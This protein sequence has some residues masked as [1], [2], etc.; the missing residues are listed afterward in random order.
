MA[1]IGSRCGAA[2]L[3]ALLLLC[4]CWLDGARGVPYYVGTIAGNGTWGSVDGVGTSATFTLMYAMVFEPVTGL[5]VV[6]DTYSAKIRSVNVTD[7]TVIT[8]AGWLPAG[9]FNYSKFCWDGTG[10]NA[11]VYFPTGIVADGR[12]NVV[13]CD[14]QTKFIRNTSVSAS[15]YSGTVT[16]WTTPSACATSGFSG[17]SYM[18]AGFTGQMATANFNQPQFLVTDASGAL[19]FFEQGGAA[20]TVTP[21]IRKVVNGAISTVV[22]DYTRNGNRFLAQ[23]MAVD[24]GGNV[25]ITGT[26]NNINVHYIVKFT[27]TG[28]VYDGGTV[29]AGSTTSGGST[30]GTGT[31]ALLQSPV[32]LAVD[33]SDNLYVSAC[34][35]G[36]ADAPGV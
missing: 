32:G 4:V 27:N 15:P 2:R 17:S 13:F 3:C 20:G 12:G 7:G 22:Y 25:F 35:A 29:F 24:S 26:V 23:G 28:G 9:G 6:S 36:C 21:S 19:Y 14:S 5:L 8:Q 18:G 31:S 1:V 10:A 34:A 33:A 30:D 16:T 11:V